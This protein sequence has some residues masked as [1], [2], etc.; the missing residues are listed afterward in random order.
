MANYF[1]GI[2]VQ[3][4]HSDPKKKPSITCP[5]WN[6]LTYSCACKAQ[7]PEAVILISSSL[8]HTP[9]PSMS[10]DCDSQHPSTLLITVLLLLLLFIA[11]FYVLFSSPQL[12][13]LNTHLQSQTFPESPSR[14]LVF[15]TQAKQVTFCFPHYIISAIHVLNCTC[16][17]L[18]SSSLRRMCILG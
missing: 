8:L 10:Y 6:Y 7:S 17:F 11:G 5:S 13:H 4:S 3:P 12:T 18:G 15:N 9:A 14:S 16:T 2:P 1:Y